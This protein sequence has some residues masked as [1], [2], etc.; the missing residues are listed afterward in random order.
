MNVGAEKGM[1]GEVKFDAF[2][3]EGM[4]EGTVVGTDRLAY[5]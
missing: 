5:R 1:E 4:E 3:L 2:E